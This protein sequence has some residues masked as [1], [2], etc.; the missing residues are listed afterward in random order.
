MMNLKCLCPY[1]PSFHKFCVVLP[2]S[3]NSSSG[4]CV[5]SRDNMY[6]E[7]GDTCVIRPTNSMPAMKDGAMC[8]HPR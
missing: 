3:S 2:M 6:T 4:V 5:T 8:V 1:L 7:S